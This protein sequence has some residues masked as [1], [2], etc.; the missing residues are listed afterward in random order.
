MKGFVH[1]FYPNKPRFHVYPPDSQ[2]SQQ[3][4][5][6]IVNDLKAVYFVRDFAG[7]VPSTGSGKNSWMERS[8]LKDGGWR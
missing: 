4:I 6:V 8:P 5:E 2:G 7:G 3:A 1:D